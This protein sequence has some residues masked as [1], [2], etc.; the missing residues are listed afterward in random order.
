MRNER[1]LGLTLFEALIVLAILA[2]VVVILFPVFARP[3]HTGHR[4]Y[5]ISNLKQLALAT[6]MYA[7]DYD[8]HLPPAEKWMDAIYPYHKNSQIH[9]D[10][11][12][13][14]SEQDEYGIAFFDPVSLADLNA[15]ANVGDVPMVFQSVLMGKNAHSDLRTLPFVSR[16]KS[17]VNF[18]ALLDG[19]VKGF[20][21]TWPE[22]PITI[23]LDP[24][25][26]KGDAK[27]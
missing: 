15:I 23:V 10:P 16:N 7:A 8:E 14:D 17:P 18:V 22:H 25:S 3:S 21:P 12:V 5:V 9:H 26:N 4:N 11:T 19:H 1:S 6:M 24:S 27:E 2:I 20:P 13:V